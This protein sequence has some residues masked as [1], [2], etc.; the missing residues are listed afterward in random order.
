MRILQCLGGEE[1]EGNEIG[2]EEKEGEMVDEVRGEGRGG[3]GG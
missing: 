2:L 1:G 3:D